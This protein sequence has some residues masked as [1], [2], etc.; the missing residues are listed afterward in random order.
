LTRPFT[1][2]TPSPVL[3]VRTDEGPGSA[4]AAFTAVE[5]VA[6]RA[7]PAGRNAERHVTFY[8][9]AGYKGQ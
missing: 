8:S 7:L 3:L 1:A 2:S 6:E 9:L 4:A 5:K